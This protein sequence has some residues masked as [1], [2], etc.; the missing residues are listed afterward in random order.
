M[1]LLS[2]N[3]A[4]LSILQLTAIFPIQ[5]P[6][7]LT[8]LAISTITAEGNVSGS[9]TMDITVGSFEQRVDGTTKTFGT[10]SGSNNWTF[11]NLTFSNSNGSTG[12]TIDTNTEG[13]GTI[14][15]NGNLLVSKTGDSQ[16]TTL[17]AGNRTWTLANADGENPFDL[18]QASG[19]LTAEIST[20]SYTGDSDSGN[21]TVENATYTNISFGGTVVET[22]KPEGDITVTGNLTI[23]ANG[24]LDVS[25][26]GTW[27]QRDVTQGYIAKG[28]T[29]SSTTPQTQNTWLQGL[30]IM[31]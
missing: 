4:H 22:Y 6:L 28:L 24:T 17:Q 25:G 29:P 27:T 11:N 19:V 16:A 20:F 1:T 7:L 21:V 3:Q 13:S 26:G 10:T 18:D 30:S 2:G 9:G 12:A 5:E 14:T 31:I 23:N 8:A 15:I